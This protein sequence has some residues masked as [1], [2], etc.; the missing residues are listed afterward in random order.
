MKGD[1]IVTKIICIDFDNTICEWDYPDA[2][3]P[4]EGVKEALQELKSSGYEIHILSCRTNPELKKHVIDRREQ[5]RFMEEYLSKHE[6]PFDVVLNEF[7]PLA[8]YYVDERAL[9]FKDNW[10]DIVKRI[11]EQDE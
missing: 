7:K 11:K 4:K 1:V 9:E 6:I 5:V 2:G 8:L 3:P 10:A